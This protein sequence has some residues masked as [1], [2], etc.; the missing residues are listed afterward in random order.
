MQ[1]NLR[2]IMYFFSHNSVI[3]K[4]LPQLSL[5]FNSSS[6]IPFYFR[7][8]IPSL[9]Q[10]A[11]S[12]MFKI[13]FPEANS[14]NVRVLWDCRNNLNIL[15]SHAVF[16]VVRRKVRSASSQFPLGPGFPRWRRFVYFLS[17]AFGSSVL[18]LKKNAGM[19]CKFL[20]VKLI[21][22]VYSTAD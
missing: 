6:V 15:D 11:S 3:T 16:A 21:S 19:F 20:G 7:K 14:E 9:Y 10:K 1:G 17:W 12:L 2:N 4:I 22:G 18:S 8:A 5:L 13:V